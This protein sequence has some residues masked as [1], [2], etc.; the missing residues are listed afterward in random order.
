L[1]P[2]VIYGRHSPQT[3]PRTAPAARTAVIISATGPPASKSPDRRQRSSAARFSVKWRRRPA[4]IRGSS[5]NRRATTKCAR[6]S[7]RTMKASRWPRNSELRARCAA[8]W[9][10]RVI[11]RDLRR[12]SGGRSRRRPGP[13]RWLRTA[14][15][16]LSTTP[17]SLGLV[18]TFPRR[19]TGVP[20]N[21]SF[22]RSSCPISANGIAAGR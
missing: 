8:D 9:P 7:I 18:G 17:P 22:P 3:R 21:S 4:R 2:N 11:L 6:D 1:C 10:N 12:P 20:F 5:K 19:A 14:P 16:T 15:R 13:E